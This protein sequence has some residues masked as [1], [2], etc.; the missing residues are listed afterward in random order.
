M[1]VV[2]D[3]RTNLDDNGD[4]LIDRY[5]P[6]LAA[7]YDYY[8]FGMLMPGRFKQDSASH[9]MVSTQTMLVPVTI[10]V[11]GPVSGPLVPVLGG[12]GTVITGGVLVSSHSPGDGVSVSTPVTAGVTITLELEVSQLSGAP[13]AVLVKEPV[14]AQDLVLGGATLSASGMY[15]VTVTPGGSTLKLVYVGGGVGSVVIKPWTWTKSLLTPKNVPVLVC[16]ETE[17]Y[18]FGFNGQQKDN[19]IAGVGNHLDFKFRGY[20]SR[21]G[22]FWSVDPLTKKFPWWSS[23]QYAGNSPIGCVDLE[24]KES[25]INIFMEDSKRNLKSVFYKEVKPAGPLGNGALTGT[26]HANGQMDMNYTEWD[27]TG[28]MIKNATAT[29]NSYNMT[30]GGSQGPLIFRPLAVIG[31]AIE[32]FGDKKFGKLKGGQADA[33]DGQAGW[34][35]HGQ[36][37]VKGTANALGF[38]IGLGEIYSAKTLVGLGLSMTDAILTGDD[39]AGNLGGMEDVTPIESK[40]SPKGRV[41]LSGLKTFFGARSAVQGG[42]GILKGINGVEPGEL[43][44]NIFSTGKGTSD[45]IESGE[46]THTQVKELSSEGRK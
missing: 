15:K 39:L 5:S 12:T 26:Y 10:K 22:R 45:A 14:G 7:V 18:R 4:T 31:K 35:N 6:S 30:E 33:Y 36:H 19:E 17:D 44:K 21:I 23:Y 24:G 34:E 8:P 29:Y 11:A 46:K 1:A 40:L 43:G 9:C 38:V 41:G 20:D 42:A 28:N 13:F 3:K 37:W 2:S 25:S 27:K 16:N 32:D